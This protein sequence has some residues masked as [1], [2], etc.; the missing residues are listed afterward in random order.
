MVVP[1]EREPKPALR[2]PSPRALPLGLSIAAFL[3]A[4]TL[5]VVALR[6]RELTPTSAALRAASEEPLIWI[7]G[8]EEPA[9][10]PAPAPSADGTAPDSAR[11]V[12]VAPA[13]A[14]TVA[15]LA[16]PRLAA[17]RH[18]ASGAAPTPASSAE[19]TSLSSASSD[20]GLLP[21]AGDGS[22]EAVGEG[23]AA[24]SASDAPSLSLDALGVGKNPFLT[25]PPATTAADT[26]IALGRRIDHVLRSGLAAH[27][28]ELGLGPEGPALTA[29]TQLVMQSA[30]RPN[31]SARIL[32]RTDAS[33]EVIHVEMAD[34]SGDTAGWNTVA[35]DLLKSLRGKK[36]RVPGGTGGVTMQLR[37]DSREQLPS[38]ADPGLAV[39]L[40]GLEVKKGQG[41][42]STRVQVL[43]P[44][45]ELGTYEL[46]KDDPRSKIPVIGVS[47]TLFSLMG[48]PTDIGAPARRV[49]HA[50]L[51]SMETHPLAPP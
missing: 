26:R 45:I 48:D 11:D 35:A 30:T 50:H 12:T 43:T 15:A 6:V 28:Q 10:P 51:V 3:H 9:V 1:R 2:D 21:E 19:S 8:I 20:V 37:V 42:R 36:L 18:S 34:A 38:G 7:D 49:V 44:K 47:L 33:G 41:D 29:V 24:A 46:V 4:F 39:D 17:L 23:A 25:P 40:F 27:D 31:T 16:R 14:P 5:A 13:A 22:S 32:L